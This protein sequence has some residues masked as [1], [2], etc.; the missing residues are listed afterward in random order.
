MR[1]GLSNF[2]S[3]Y[4]YWYSTVLVLA[5]RERHDEIGLD[6]NTDDVDGGGCDGRAPTEQDCDARLPAPAR[7]AEGRRLPREV[8]R[9]CPRRRGA[10]GGLVR[11]ERGGRRR[12]C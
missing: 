4:L 1:G 10:A 2:E 3:I 11:V 9:G 6:I 12:H 8:P 5:L 7:K